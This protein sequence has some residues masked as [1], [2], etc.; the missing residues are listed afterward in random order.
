MWQYFVSQCVMHFLTRGWPST[1]PIQIP[2]DY[3]LITS[4]PV[5]ISL[6]ENYHPISNKTTDINDAQLM[7]VSYFIT[8]LFAHHPLAVIQT[9][10]VFT[11]IIT[12]TKKITCVCWRRSQASQLADPHIKTYHKAMLAGYWLSQREG[13]RLVALLGCNYGL[14]R[15]FTIDF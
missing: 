13:V 4:I 5:S 7:Q 9:N 8:A 12:L 2:H 14:L 1:S 11:C 15:F 6:I 3:C 10:Q